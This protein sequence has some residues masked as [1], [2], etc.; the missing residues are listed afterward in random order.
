MSLVFACAVSHTP[1][2][3][4]WPDAPG[5]K[6]KNNFYTE[7]EN[8]YKKMMAAH[9]EVLV[10][11]SSE[12]FTNFFLDCMP[13]F[14][15]GMADQYFGPIEQWINVE[16][17]NISGDPNLA[18]YLL[19][20]SYSAGIELAYAHEM[21]LD[22]GIMIPLSFLNPKRKLPIVP[23]II[24]AMTYPMPS[25]KRCYELGG[26]LSKALEKENKR[27][28]VIA[29][30]GLSHA[31]GEPTHGIIDEKFDRDFLHQLTTNDSSTF[32]SYTDQQ[33]ET[34]GLGTHE[35]RTWVTVAGIAKKLKAKIL[36]YEPIS[37]WA[38]GCGILYY[39]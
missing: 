28:A 8:L 37:A 32:T 12:H 6:I 29:A 27:V 2:I 24:N 18:K 3:R 26:V 7:F 17:G 9:P 36:F 1:G 38:T 14:T 16:Q 4:A 15:I 23:L 19:H 10:I 34:S 5:A 22:H 30:G 35:I 21:K 20:S 33:L 25:Q 11:I 39:E 13:A 31:P